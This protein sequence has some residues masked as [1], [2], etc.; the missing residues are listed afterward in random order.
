MY[1]LCDIEK[2]IVLRS[3]WTVYLC[4]PLSKRVALFFLNTFPLSPNSVTTL[5]VSFRFLTVVSFLTNSH[6]FHCC[7]SLFFY[8]AHMLDGVDGVVARV[9][10]KTSTFGRYYDHISDLVGDVLIML[11]LAYSSS[12]ISSPVILALV[13][14]HMAESYISYMFSF[15]SLSSLPCEN[16]LFLYFNKYRCSFFDKNCKSFFS[17]PDYTAFVFIVMPVF[18]MAGLGLR[19][20]FY[21]LFVIVCYTILSTF[22]SL[23]TGENRFP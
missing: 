4:D 6:F 12:M 1:T 22:V 2:K 21:F 13:F 23:H 8:F 10:G 14:M 9:S 17:Y 20:G 16:T 15:C 3:W 5:S 19:I 7:G 11:S 18:D